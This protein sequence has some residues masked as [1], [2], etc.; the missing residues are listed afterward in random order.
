M[1]KRNFDTLG[2]GGVIV[3]VVAITSIVEEVVLVVGLWETV[4]VL[5]GR[6]RVVVGKLVLRY[7]QFGHVLSSPKRVLQFG[8]YLIPDKI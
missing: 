7:P 2:G 6:E 5:S 8:Q 4:T 1:V 3:A